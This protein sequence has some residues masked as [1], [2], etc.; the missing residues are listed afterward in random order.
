MPRHCPV[1][2]NSFW[3]D[4]DP[5][6]VPAS[7]TPTPRALLTP[8]T[9]A[10]SGAFVSPSYAVDASEVSDLHVISYEPE[11]DLNSLILSCCQ[12]SVEQGA[13]ALQDVDL[14]KLQRQL[15]SRFLQGK[16]KL[17]LKVGRAGGLG[18]HR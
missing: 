13:K 6:L 5:W 12:Y 9:W 8:L 2:V 15:I 4:H 3:E 18:S 10:L 7:P 16:P 14:D 1:P 17:T 11:R